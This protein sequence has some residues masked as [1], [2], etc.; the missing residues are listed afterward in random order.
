M[1]IAPPARPPSATTAR[2]TR[3]VAD[4]RPEAEA[5]G[6]RL[7]DL[8]AEPDALVA[9]LSDGFA[10]LAD[11][12]YIEGQRRVAPGIGPLFG[13]RWPLVE[14]VKRGF[15]RA[16]RPDRPASLLLVAARLFEGTE[17][18]LR[19]FAFGLLERLVADDPERTW[20]LLRRAGQEAADWIT[21]DS[22]RASRGEG[23]R[24]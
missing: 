22:A 16:T 14:A 17:L 11:P 23:H 1:T 13:V 5:L 18:E 8:V 2:S 10:R 6:R 21:V 19:W 20:Q 4:R 15:R 12:E 9:E 24:R 7:G 3:F